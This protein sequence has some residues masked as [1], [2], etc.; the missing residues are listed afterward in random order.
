MPQSKMV[1]LTDLNTE[2]WLPNAK[3]FVFEF[4]ESVVRLFMLELQSKVLSY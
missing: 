1:T 2:K 3:A 4:Q